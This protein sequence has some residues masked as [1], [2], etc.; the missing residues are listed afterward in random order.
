MSS[1]GGPGPKHNVWALQMEAKPKGYSKL[2]CS[3]T[4]GGL[5]RGLGS[6]FMPCV[7]AGQVIM[8][9]GSKAELE[10]CDPGFTGVN[11]SE[12]VVEVWISHLAGSSELVELCSLLLTGEPSVDAVW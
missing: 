3:E 9:G 10:I 4:P 8:H 2:H 11:T 12:V 1:P 5:S 7:M 6:P